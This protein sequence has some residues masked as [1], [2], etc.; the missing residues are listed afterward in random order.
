MVSSIFLFTCFAKLKPCN[1]YLALFILHVNEHIGFKSEQVLI[2]IR[3]LVFIKVLKIKTKLSLAQKMNIT[4]VFRWFK[5][6]ALQILK[7]SKYTL[8]NK[9]IPY[10]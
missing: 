8:T 7:L 10:L 6:I 9:I 3:H 4:Q 1:N 5:Y 2:K